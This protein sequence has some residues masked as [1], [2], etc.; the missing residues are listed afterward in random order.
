VA[1]K[2]ILIALVLAGAAIMGTGAFVFQSR[3]PS[4][5]GRTLSAW[6]ND[7]DADKME[8]REQAAQ[9][10]RQIGSNAVAAGLVPWQRG[11]SPGVS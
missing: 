3:E 5:H 4:W 8:K 10:L 2:R 6:L 7:F 1:R 9:A 11:L